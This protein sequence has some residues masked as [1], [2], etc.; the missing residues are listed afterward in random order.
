MADQASRVTAT[1]KQ[2]DV[3]AQVDNGKGTVTTPSRSYT[4]DPAGKGKYCIR[5][6]DGS[7]DLTYDN[8]TRSLTTDG[9]T[10]TPDGV[11]IGDISMGYDGSVSDS[12]L[13]II[14]SDDN[15]SSTPGA[16]AAGDEAVRDELADTSTDV[17]NALADVG[18][19]EANIGDLNELR[20]ELC[21]LEMIGGKL[22]DGAV[23]K[24]NYAKG[25]VKSAISA[26]SAVV[27]AA[28]KTVQ[29]AGVE[30]GDLTREVVQDGGNATAVLGRHHLRP[31]ADDQQQSA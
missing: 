7:D 23:A 28:Q 26:L 29:I 9:A 1:T 6:S 30:N 12:F 17:A 24:L 27:D 31:V 20:D 10:F 25:T 15:S 11:Q 3:S 2:G 13:K 14:D 5:N 22:S 21:E 16:S 18:R 19:F 4:Y 8:A